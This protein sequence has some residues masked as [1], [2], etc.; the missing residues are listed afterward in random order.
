MRK[1]VVSLGADQATRV[2]NGQS[3][4]VRPYSGGPPIGCGRMFHRLT[5][6]PRF[7]PP[8]DTTN[9]FP[10]STARLRRYAHGEPTGHTRPQT[11]TSPYM[12][13][14]GRRRGTRVRRMR[15]E[16]SSRLGAHDVFGLP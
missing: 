13:E 7:R 4:V 15:T 6:D 3:L 11:Q 14:H 12:R 5:V 1:E 10:F 16:L 9:M 8:Q 2:V